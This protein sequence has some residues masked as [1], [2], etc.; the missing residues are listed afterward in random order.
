MKNYLLFAGSMYYPSGG[1][2]DFRGSYESIY[3]AKS[4][5]IDIIC[6]WYHIVDASTGK[7]VLDN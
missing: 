3:A 6:D 2:H 7:I 1:W 4:A 5:V